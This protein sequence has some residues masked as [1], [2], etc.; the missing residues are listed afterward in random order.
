MTKA[1]VSLMIAALVASP[2]VVAAQDAVAT[3]VQGSLDTRMVQPECKIEGGDFRVSSGK[4]YLKTGIEG[5]GDPSNRANA[6]RNG[7][8]VVTEAIT[9]GKQ[10]KSSAAWYWLGRIYLQQGDLVGAD[11][12]FTRTL[13]LAPGCKDEIR[14]YRYRAWAAL[15]NAG[16]SFRQANQN[17]SAMVMYRA[18]NL[19]FSEG[20]LSYVNMADIFNAAGQT[21]S[22]LYYFGRAAATEPTD[23]QQ[24]KLRDQA[25]FNHGVLLLNSG[26]AANAI[27]V[28]RRY[29]TFQPDDMSAKKGLA[30]AFR[31]AGLP[32]SAQ[33]LEREL[34]AGAGQA[35]G[36]A[37]PEAAEGLSEGDLMDI[38]VRQFNDK[39]Y[40]EAAATFDRIVSMNAWNRDALYNLANAYLAQQDGGKLAV[41]AEKL[42]AIEPLAEYDHTL[43]LEGYKLAGNQNAR[44]EASVA[45]EALLVNLEIERMVVTADG[46]TLSGKL[47]GRE[48]RDERSKLIAPRPLTITVEFLTPSGTVLASQ[49]VQIAALKTGETAAFQA[50]AKAPGIKAWRYRVK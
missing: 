17:D 29:L 40:R 42:I 12:A 4:T 7:A 30:Q 8:R 45:R 35:A 38:G 15:V 24:V 49:D 37:S 41:T 6:L 34:V 47:T 36:A 28:F 18:A 26:Q 31:A 22:A 13:A 11:S 23:P 50:T 43:R 46:A 32:D 44:L 20:P 39:N 48:A 9:V 14:K 16:S 25:A 21:D 5:S 3:R 33:A 1:L 10:S 2:G 19:I 27:P